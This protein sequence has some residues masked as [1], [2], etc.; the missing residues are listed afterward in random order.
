MEFPNLLMNSNVSSKYKVRKEEE[1]NKDFERQQFEVTRKVVVWHEFIPNKRHVNKLK[2]WTQPQMDRIKLQ[3]RRWISFHNKLTSQHQYSWAFVELFIPSPH[4]T[5]LNTSFGLYT[6]CPNSKHKFQHIYD[7]AAFIT[8][9]PWIELLFYHHH[10][11]HHHIINIPQKGF[12]IF[13]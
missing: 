10:H 11:H 6:Y 9:V 13:T 1:S 12:L 4:T 5:D 2:S 8:K 3:R 7:P